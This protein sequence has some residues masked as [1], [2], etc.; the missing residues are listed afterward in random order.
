MRKFPLSAITLAVAAVMVPLSSTCAAEDPDSNVGFHFELGEGVVQ[1][2][3]KGQTVQ[4]EQTL[5][6]DE[7]QWVTSSTWLGYVWL[8]GENDNLADGK[9]QVIRNMKYGSNYPNH[10]TLVLGDETG[11]IPFSN[12]AENRLELNV[13]VT[14][15]SETEKKLGRNAPE[16]VFLTSPQ[17]KDVLK[18]ENLILTGDYALAIPE[19]IDLMSY[20]KSKNGGEELWVY[21]PNNEVTLKSPD[22]QKITIEGVSIVT[23]SNIDLTLGSSI[24]AEINVDALRSEYYYD[25]LPSYPGYLNYL[26]PDKKIFFEKHNKNGY[27]TDLNNNYLLRTGFGD[28]V[29]GGELVL[30]IG[31]GNEDLA[32]DNFIWEFDGQ[33]GVDAAIMHSDVRGNSAKIT[34]KQTLHIVR[35]KSNSYKNRPGLLKVVLGE[36]SKYTLD[37]SSLHFDSSPVSQKNLF[38]VE[39]RGKSSQAKL[40]FRSLIQHK[41]DEYINFTN[42]GDEFPYLFNLDAKVNGTIHVDVKDRVDLYG[43][44]ILRLHAEDE[45]EVV[46]NLPASG[47]VHVD[48]SKATDR[49]RIGLP[50]DRPRRYEDIPGHEELALVDASGNATVNIKNTKGSDGE[51]ENAEYKGPS[52]LRN[53]ATLNVELDGP[54]NEFRGPISLRD[55]IDHPEPQKNDGVVNMTLSNGAE[56]AVWWPQRK[57]YGDTRDEY[58]MK[59]YDRLIFDD[60]KRKQN[61]YVP[62]SQIT[63][64]TLNGGRVDLHS[65][66]DKGETL[67]GIL[68]VGKLVGKTN[69]GDGASFENPED[70]GH[71]NSGTISLSPDVEGSPNQSFLHVTGSSEGWFNLDIKDGHNLTGNVTEKSLIPIV[72]NKEPDQAKA[73][74]KTVVNGGFKNIYEF[75][76]YKFRRQMIDGSLYLTAYNEGDDP[77]DDGQGKEKPSQGISPIGDDTKL[78][79]WGETGYGGLAVQYLTATGGLDTLR[80][81]LGEARRFHEASEGTTPW[82]RMSGSRWKENK[83]KRAR[84]LRYDKSHV[85]AGVDHVLSGGSIAG[86]FVD[87]NY[88]RAKMAEGQK[89][90]SQGARLGLYYNAEHSSGAWVDLVARAGFN[91][92]EI[93]NV[94]FEGEHIKSERPATGFYG[95][96]SVETGMPFRFAR[97]WSLEPRVQAVYTRL[98]TVMASDNHGGN[99]RAESAS[100][101]ISRVSGLLERRIDAAGDTDLRVYGTLGWER[102]WMKA[103]KVAFNHGPTLHFK[104]KGDRVRYGLGIEGTTK[105]SSTWHASVTRA[106]GGAFDAELQA[107][108]GVRFAF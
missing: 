88:G 83:E 32:N 66:T 41:P 13:E 89:I 43:P 78:N 40:L 18:P 77:S 95:N 21:M 94:V 60:E 17:K 103:P 54:G 22:E 69:I 44:K 97:G 108:F 73:I 6:P 96:L 45:S 75:D 91:R 67:N 48:Y 47:K 92:L 14:E 51:Y 5:K 25:P 29:A 15:R 26:N 61:P 72:I 39:A 58:W 87:Y 8:I 38:H 4:V 23:P 46:V 65:Y 1:V 30:N 3:K 50:W 98:G 80:E 42:E 57:A 99:I 19:K 62:L 52:T 53:G 28:V 82:I 20:A 2:D 11:T 12:N 64:L 86:V 49:R 100:S 68:E 105:G 7:S 35:E 37:S 33:P 76:A 102:E 101:L 71:C 59:K 55:V 36:G 27:Y 90:R 24:K 106:T 10:F 104:W 84:G 34:V 93:S 31:V 107:D 85:E 81:R 56:Y 70:F 63:E 74:Y 16:F 9:L 79:V